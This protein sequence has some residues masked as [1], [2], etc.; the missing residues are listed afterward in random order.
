MEVV[1]VGA[2]LP[3]LFI[4]DLRIS[5]GDVNDPGTRVA[6][7][8]GVSGEGPVEASLTLSAGDANGG[9]GGAQAE[10]QR[11]N[12]AMRAYPGRLVDVFFKLSP[13]MEKA[14]LFKVEVSPRNVGDPGS[15]NSIIEDDAGW[16]ARKASGRSAVLLISPDN[17]AQAA[18]LAKITSL[19]VEQLRPEVFAQQADEELEK[20]ALL[21][22][23]KSAPAT[24]LK[25]PVLLVLPP[26]DNPLFPASG[27]FAS[28]KITSWID[29]HPINSYLRLD[30]LEPGAGL[31][32]AVPVWAQAVINTEPG[33]VVAAG[34]SRGIRFAG[35]GL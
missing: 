28:A 10:D 35:R 2:A 27:E 29:E 12:S 21:I 31:V 32:F 26:A 16:A 7:S 23:H 1:A 17:L 19:D 15:V 8:V 34:E 14:E 24:A 18:G 30:L 20:Y 22:F 25:K 5:S 6:A 4:A 3:N 33:A 11:V 13:A 9:S